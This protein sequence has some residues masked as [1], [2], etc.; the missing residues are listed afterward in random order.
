MP[1]RLPSYEGECIEIFYLSYLEFHFIVPLIRGEYRNKIT[2]HSMADGLSP[3]IR[4]ECIE[5][6]N[7]ANFR[8]VWMSPLIRGECIEI[9]LCRQGS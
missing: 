5:I 2:G 4:G 8:H 1:S 7:S 3:L 9:S 6:K